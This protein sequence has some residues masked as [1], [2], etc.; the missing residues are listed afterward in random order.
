MPHTHFCVVS[1]SDIA[2][3]RLPHFA[4]AKLHKFSNACET[5]LHAI[6]HQWLTVTYPTDAEICFFDL[7][8]FCKEELRLARWRALALAAMSELRPSGIT[9]EKY[10]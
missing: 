1:I 3:A 10:K 7:L 5:S 2:F 4:H 8:S 9:K 6:Y